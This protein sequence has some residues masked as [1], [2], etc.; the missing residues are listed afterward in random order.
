MFQ[1]AYILQ[2]GKRAIR[3]RR[4]EAHVEQSPGALPSRIY[5]WSRVLVVN[6]PGLEL[7]SVVTYAINFIRYPVEEEKR[8]AR[9]RK[10]DWPILAKDGNVFTRTGQ[11]F[12]LRSWS[13][14]SDTVRIAARDA[15]V[16][17][18][19]ILKLSGATLQI[20]SGKAALQEKRGLNSRDEPYY[21]MFRIS[22]QGSWGELLAN[23]RDSV[24]KRLPAPPP[25]AGAKRPE[26][27]E[28][29]RLHRFIH[30][31]LRYVSLSFGERAYV[32]AFPDSVLKHRMGDCKDFSVL[33]IDRMRRAGIEAWP[34][35]I[36]SRFKN[37]LFDGPPSFD[38]TDHMVVYLPGRDWWVDPT[39]APTPPDSIVRRRIPAVSDTDFTLGISYNCRARGSDLVCRKQTVQTRRV[40]WGLRSWLTQ[41]PREKWAS[42]LHPEEWQAPFRT[43]ETST[44]V[45]NFDARVDRSA[46]EDTAKALEF[47]ETYT[48]E[49]EFRLESDRPWQWPTLK[50]I[51]GPGYEFKVIPGKSQ[52]IRVRL[53]IAEG[54]YEGA[55]KAAVKAILREY[56]DYFS[57]SLVSG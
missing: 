20:L 5:D 29:T 54:R 19:E 8:P 56:K 17:P 39:T 18:P 42:L 47:E 31:S 53:H 16:T 2:P 22:N 3:V 43:T 27:E 40:S 23:T 55:D 38:A 15:E 35:L 24:L 49:I 9:G 10:R 33:F 41:V 6:L 25:R 57:S 11:T 48:Y 4:E 30:D 32:P 36:H 44:G 37:H 34:A 45:P 46:E 14:P 26:E 50:P 52:V 28:V 51:R 12:Q 7:G 21:P 13:V 1:Y